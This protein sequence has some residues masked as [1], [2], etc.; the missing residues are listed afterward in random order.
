MKHWKIICLGTALAVSAAGCLFFGVRARKAVALAATHETILFDRTA[1]P[2]EPSPG[3]KPS[4]GTTEQG[5]TENAGSGSGTSGQTA[6]ET[7][8]SGGET[9]Y[10]DSGIS[11]LQAQ[12]QKTQ[13]ERV[14]I[15]QVLNTLLEGQNDFIKELQDLDQTILDYQD[16]LDNLKEQQ[17]I[18][19]NTLTSL[20][21]NLDQA[22]AEEDRQYGI[23]KSHIQDEYEN[24]NY[25]I[26]DVLF[27]SDS[28]IDMAVKLEY[29][30]AVDAYDQNALDKLKDSR[31]T[32]LNKQALYSSMEG[33]ID[34]L[35]KLYTEQ[36]DDLNTLS[37]TKVEEINAYQERIDQA[38][39]DLKTIQDLENATDQ[40]ITEIEERYRNSL[41]ASGTYTGGVFTWPMPASSL[42]TSGYGN[43]SRPNVAG[44]TAFHGGIDIACSSGSEVVA[45]APG[46]VIYAA[47][48]GTAGNAVMID[49]GGGIST[50]YYHLSQFLCQPGD[51]V[52]AGQ[53]IALSGS[54]GAST[55]P[56]LHFS[57]RLNGQYT[58]PLPY[59][60]MGSSQ[61]SE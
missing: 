1:S 10:T 2:G 3:G 30:Q 17:E 50:C 24:G 57:V 31:Q 37:Q 33:D 20:Q 21:D 44:A 40:Q 8:I 5:T 42:I 14:E 12:L 52:S 15:Q 16:R 43:R 39:S 26:L 59:L 25:N 61:A 23:L 55:G 48:L 58:D 38:K 34:T 6:P 29:V 18:A 19:R 46:T 47:Y 7:V 56:H 22:K 11:A 32:L 45:A 51:T 35:D 49:H 28:Y 9:I 4:E 60:G 13:S 36:Q 53:V 54:T 27:Q 41:T